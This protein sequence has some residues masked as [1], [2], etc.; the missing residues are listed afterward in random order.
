MGAILALG[1]ALFYGIADYAGGLL[2]RRADPTLIALIGQVGALILT[3]A[4]APFVPTPDLQ[5]QD[6]AWGALSGVGT[7]MGMVFLYRGLSHGSMSVVVPLVAV[8][9]T[10]IPVLIGVTLLG[11]RP[12]ALAWLGIA[13]A[14]P[15]L[16]LISVTRSRAGATHASGAFDAL[17]SSL[18]I[19]LQYI[20]LAQAG[21]GAG[22]WPIVAGRV[23]ASIAILPLARRTLSGFRNLS[24]SMVLAAAL[25]GGTAALAL[26]LYMLAAQLQLTT[27]AVVLSSLYPVIPVLL[28]IT[29]LREKLTGRQILG[30]IGAGAAVGLITLG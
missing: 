15:A 9:G 26:T 12:S 5:L 19:A 22:L 13:F 29:L 7:G 11:D 30:L 4:V 6:V 1:S 21:D 18:G 8:G 28:G 3:L 2:S 25:I 20:A 10:A 23:A 24:L 17:F 27:I 14:I 16:W